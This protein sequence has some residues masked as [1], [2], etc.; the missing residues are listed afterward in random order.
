M[1]KTSLLVSDCKTNL[2]WQFLNID[3]SENVLLPEESDATHRTFIFALVY[4]GLYG[5]LI[6]TALFSLTGINNSCLGRRSFP[7]FFAPWIFVSCSII[8]MDVLA[9]IYYIMD[10]IST[11][12]RTRELSDDSYFADFN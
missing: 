5:A 12:V 2:E 9:T 8:V 7:I 6:F 10:L 3:S 4:V 11:T 1:I